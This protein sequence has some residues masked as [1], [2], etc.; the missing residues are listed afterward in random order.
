MIQDITYLIASFV[1]LIFS[2][3]IHEVAHGSMAYAL[4][5]MTAKMQGRLSLNPIKHIDLIGTIIL[6]LGLVLINSPV[7]FGWAKPVPVNFLNLKDK[8]WG[9]LK[10]ALAGPVT[11]LIIAIL[12]GLVIRLFVLPEGMFLILWLAVF[13]NVLLAIFNLIPIPPLDGSHILFSLVKGGHEVKAFLAQW[14]FLI[15]AFVLFMPTFQ[16][17]L[18]E[19]IGGI[20]KLMTGVNI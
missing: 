8:K 3:V 16:I 9:A 2:I 12:C 18:F 11:N 6:P 20:V 15:L 13:Y 1:V 19:V 17:L 5:D 10:V 7:V 4:G 14:G